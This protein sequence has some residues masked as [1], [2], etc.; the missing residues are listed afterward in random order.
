MKTAILFFLIFANLLFANKLV[1]SGEYVLDD[2]NR[3]MWQDSYDNVKIRLDQPNAVKC[4]LESKYG[5][6]R[7]R[8]HYRLSAKKES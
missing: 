1:K 5:K 3:L 7:L 6:L 4:I 8:H 2:A